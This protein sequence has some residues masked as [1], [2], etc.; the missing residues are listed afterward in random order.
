MNTI[1]FM[2]NAKTVAVHPSANMVYNGNNVSNAVVQPS[3]SMVNINH[4]VRNVEV[5]LFANIIGLD[6]HAKNVTAAVSASMDGIV[7]LAKIAG[8]HP[9]ASTVKFSLPA[10]NAAV[11]ESAK[12][13][14]SQI[15][16]T[17]A[18]RNTIT[19]ARCVFGIYS[20]TILVRH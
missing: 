4:V 10:W 11:V 14:L 2:H 13:M 19:T 9:S 15:A 18:I 17:S 16:D 20:R 3:A 12:A 5:V 1:E 7:I 8:G 6:Q